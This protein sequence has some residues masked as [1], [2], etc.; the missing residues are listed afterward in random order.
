MDL[1]LDSGQKFRVYSKNGCPFC[2][3]SKSL[4]EKLNYDF[5]VVDLTDDATRFKF[6][7]DRGF[8]APN[9]TVPKV[10]DLID[11]QEVLVGGYT[12]LAKKLA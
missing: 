6:Y 1:I 11:G 4:L 2:T 7:D 8:V 9:R 12:E 3:K 5:E 10:Y